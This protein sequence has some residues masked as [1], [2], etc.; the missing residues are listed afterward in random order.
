MAIFKEIENEFKA[1]FNYHKIKEV[2]IIQTEEGT[3]LRILTESYVN[4]DARIEGAKAILIE[5]II[6]KADF[7]V[8]PFYEI[9]KAK[10]EMFKDGEDDFEDNWKQKNVQKSVFSI[11]NQNGEL[12]KQWSEID[13]EDIEFKVSEQISNESVKQV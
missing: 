4:K 11:Q 5:N 3:Q 13:S 12:I 2:R 8:K 9:L 1:K 7:A 6:E 10:F